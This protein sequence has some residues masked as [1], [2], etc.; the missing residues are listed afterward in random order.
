MADMRV[1]DGERLFHGSSA[2]LEVGAVVLPAAALGTGIC[3]FEGLSKPN[4]AYATSDLRDAM[5]FAWNC[6]F[7]SGG[8][9][10]SVYEVEAIGDV[11]VKSITP[12]YERNVPR[13]E[14]Q[15]FKGFRVLAVVERKPI[16]KG[17]LG[18]YAKEFWEG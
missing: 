9:V 15:S 3:N 1:K 8:K 10:V 13:L 5:Y 4:R 6:A 2:V 7:E 16:K 18:R 17:G 12:R 14:H 11:K